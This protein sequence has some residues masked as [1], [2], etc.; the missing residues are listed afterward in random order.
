MTPAIDAVNFAAIPEISLPR[1]DLY[2]REHYLRWLW[3]RSGWRR[4]L[5]LA[6]VALALIAVVI[7]FTTGNTALRFSV[8]IVAA[9]GFA[10]AIVPWLEFRRW[11]QAARGGLATMPDLRLSLNDGVLRFGAGP[12]VRYDAG[13]DVVVVPGGVFIYE[14]GHSGRHAFLP[15]RWLADARVRALLQGWRPERAW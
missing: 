13:G 2:V 6:S 9:A 5:W 15:K 1:D 10:Q 3:F 14:H 8:V 7:A 11:K 12:S 4:W